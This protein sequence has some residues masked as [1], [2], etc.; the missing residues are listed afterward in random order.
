MAGGI[1]IS[2]LS[3]VREFLTGTKNIEGALTDVSEGLDDVARDGQK[4]EKS[5]KDTFDTV[6]RESRQ[7]GDDV[8]RNVK[9]GF[10]GASDGA[11]DF[12]DESAGTAREVA[13]SFD[14]SAES[15]AGAFQEVAAQA[16]QGF[17]PAGQAA[18]LAAA[19]GIGFALKT[20]QEGAEAANALKDRVVELAQEISDVGG[21][22]DDIDFAGK[23]R[24]WGL[25]IADS[26]SW[27]EPWQ[28]EALTRFEE[29]EVKANGL[30]LD[31]SNLFRGMSGSDADAARASLGEIDTRLEELRATRERGITAA[32]RDVAEINHVERA[33]RDQL[34]PL[35]ALR[36]ELE[37]SSGVTDRAIALQERLDAALGGSAEATER[38]RQAQEDYQGALADAAAPID[39]Y[40]QLLTDKEAAERATAEQTA[41]ATED[42]ADSWEDYAQ[43]V[44]VTIDD[45]IAELDR[46]AELARSFE[47]NLA[48]ITAAGG[49]AVADELRAKGPEVASAVAEVIAQASP[50]QQ[51]E[52]LERYAAA[53]GTEIAAAAARGVTANAGA[54]STAV[55][56]AF[57]KVPT[58]QIDVQANVTGTGQ[59][60][61]PVA[62]P[63]APAASA[64]SQQPLTATL[65]SEDRQLLLRAISMPLN[66]EV[67][68]P[69]MIDG[70]RLVTT[71]QRLTAKR[72]RRGNMIG[73]V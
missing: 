47:T 39:T 73:A 21:N 13:A 5:F 17:G 59:V 27:F 29:L 10:D 38:V 52:Y 61:G 2:F 70:E 6:K 41:A 19:L 48:T 18:G 72:A 58:Q 45:L 7:A 55:S 50:D 31:M 11:K 28:E 37:T 54:V 32:G 25:E 53:T 57:F 71:V 16:L 30:G 1:K 46:Q 42:A 65:A 14:G 22:L 66:V 62:P 23:I 9:R 12:K 3:D 4:A 26:K 56:D 69:V 44:A 68:L 35:V 60:R 51:R 40:R 24:D 49:Q 20:F 15:V 36:N 64:G 63:G 43:D 34:D 33:Y 8:G 67:T